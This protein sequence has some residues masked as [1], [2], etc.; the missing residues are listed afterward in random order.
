MM[1]DFIDRVL[2]AGSIAL[3]L[4]GRICDDMTWYYW[5]GI[6]G[7]QLEVIGIIG[8]ACSAVMITIVRLRGDNGWKVLFVESQLR[9]IT[10]WALVVL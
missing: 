10:P 6:P 2:V 8:L 9:F 5:P 1:G 3:Y 7:N 4:L